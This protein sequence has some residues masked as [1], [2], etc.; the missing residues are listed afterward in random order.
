ME[1]NMDRLQFI[2]SIDQGSFASSEDAIINFFDHTMAAYDL[3]GKYN[4]ISVCSQ[5]NTPLC[6][7]FNISFGSKDH[8]TK[9]VDRITNDFHNKMELYGKVFNIKSN[10]TES[11]VGIQ[12]LQL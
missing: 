3:C 5:I 9:M 2:G 12:I 8:A 7:T 1:N 10:I 4:D 6:M 11:S